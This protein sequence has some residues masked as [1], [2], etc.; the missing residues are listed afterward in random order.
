MLD[1]FLVNLSNQLATT[2]D[3][4]LAVA[5]HE[6]VPNGIAE[7]EPVVPGAFVHPQH[8]VQT[9]SHAAVPEVETV[10]PIPAQVEVVEKP[11]K[12]ISKLGKGGF[13]HKH[14]SCDGCLTGIR[15]MR[16]KCEVST[17]SIVSQG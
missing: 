1:N 10:A 17:A 15:G 7:A 3:G 16:Y 6:A 9:E 2:F 8:T 11:V 14:I 4:A 13:R 5:E 12:P